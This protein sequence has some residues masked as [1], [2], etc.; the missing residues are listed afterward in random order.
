MTCDLEALFGDVAKRL[1]ET[2]DAAP[3]Y[4]VF[5]E[6]SFSA[7]PEHLS[8]DR[9]TLRWG[10]CF[11]DGWSPIDNVSFEADQATYRNLGLLIFATVFNPQPRRT[12]IEF[13]H[14]QGNI[15]KLVLEPVWDPGSEIDG[16]VMRPLQFKYYPELPTLH[17]WA[18]T[19]L[20]RWD[21]PRLYLINDKDFV[22][23]H[24]HV[25][26]RDVAVGFGNVEATSLFAELLLNVSLPQFD[27]KE[28]A[29]EGERGFGG[30]APGSAEITLWLPGG[31]G[32]L[33]TSPQTQDGV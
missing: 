4:V 23:N 32:H 5:N 22:A 19:T 25:Q 33:G 10:Y 21:M 31:I 30:V 11:Q 7:P 1:P 13:A 20:G 24:E 6:T 28:V 15:R 29:L 27:E 26:S 3:G 8:T 12:V 14:Q 2:E 9:L 17:P 16:L 18:N